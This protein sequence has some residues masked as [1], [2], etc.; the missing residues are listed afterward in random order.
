[1][2]P[3]PDPLPEPT[4]RD[5][6]IALLWAFLK[7]RLQ[8]RR[9]VAGIGEP[10]NIPHRLPGPN[11]Y[12]QDFGWRADIPLDGEGR[13][14]L[15]G[16]LRAYP[17]SLR[18]KAAT[19]P[20]LLDVVA[21]LQRQGI[22]RPSWERDAHALY[23]TGH[24]AAVLDAD[25]LGLPPGD[26]GRV[27]RLRAEFSALGDLDLISKHYGEA[28]A[29]YDVGLDYS[30]TVMIGVCY[31][32]GLVLL[33]REIAA[34]EDRSP[35]AVPGMN[36]NHKGSVAKVADGEY[37]PASALEGLVYDVFCALG[38]RLG[39]DLEWVKTCLRPTCYFVRS[40]RNSA[41]HPTG[42]AVPR[43]DIAA[44]IMMLP[45]FFRRVASLQRTV[46]ASS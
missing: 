46:G 16:L 35:G 29:A 24:G 14:L 20:M 23:I 28:I 5:E 22:L 33:A 17:D 30:A 13:S 25:D 1:M 39:D 10:K 32:A 3:R 18:P 12:E 7:L 42:K 15:G 34:Y 40:L 45:A 38:P 4:S 43:D 41:G 26:A 36:K 6:A 8:E 21:D 44:H 2:K 11:G 9:A 27:A 37:V 31:E 19:L